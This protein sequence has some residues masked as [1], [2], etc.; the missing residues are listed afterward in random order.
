MELIAQQ[1]VPVKPSQ[2]GLKYVPK[3]AEILSYQFSSDVPGFPVLEGK[4]VVE[5]RWPGKIN[6]TD[7]KLGDH[8]YTDKG[9]PQLY[10]GKIQGGK[11]V[12]KWR[13]DVLLDWARRWEWLK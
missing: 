6:S 11:T 4:L 2:Y 13:Q 8:W 10:D 1:P 9:S 5:N 3:Q 12:S 7:Y